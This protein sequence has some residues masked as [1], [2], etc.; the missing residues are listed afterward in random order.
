MYFCAALEQ[1]KLPLRCTSSTLSQSSSLILNERLSRNSP[2]LLTRM[3]IRPKRC[4]I[5]S[6]AFSTCCALDTSQAIAIASDPA[7]STASTVS[8]HASADKS[9]TA[10]FAP[11]CASRMASAAPIPRADPVTTAVRP[12]S[13][14]IHLSFAKHYSPHPERC[15]LCYMP[16][17]CIRNERMCPEQIDT[18]VQGSRAA[19]WP[20]GEVYAYYRGVVVCGIT[21]RAAPAGAGAA[22]DLLLRPNVDATVDVDGLARDVVAVLDQV[23]DGP[24]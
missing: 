11:S 23:A 10:T 21:G 12:S 3:S 14:K 16:F 6:K 4:T 13:L 22:K 19:L 5:S 1:R 18:N 24:G 7:A 17:N 15:G 9:R 8:W 2:A 20:M